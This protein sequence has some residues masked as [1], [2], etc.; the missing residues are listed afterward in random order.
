MP[1][2][3]RAA[4][5]SSQN[6]SIHQKQHIL[7]HYN[8][9]K[10]LN[11][12]Y[13][14]QD[15]ADWTRD[16]YKLSYTP[17]RSTIHRI[18]N[19]STP[20]SSSTSFK[21]KAPSNTEE[22]DRL[23]AEWVNSQPSRGVMVNGHLIKQQGQILQSRLNTSLP[24]DQQLALKFSN[25]WL[26][27]FCNRHSFKLQIAHGE[28]G[29]VQQDVIDKELPTLKLLIQQYHPADV[30]NADETGLFYNMPPNKTIGSS[31]ASGLKKNKA[32]ITIL[33]ACN[34]T[35]TEKLDP[36]FIGH[37]QQ[38]HAFKKQSPEQLG[39]Q[40][41]ANSK[42]WMTSSLFH[43]W[44]SSLDTYIGQTPGRHIL[45]LLDNFSGHG[46]LQKP[47]AKLQN[48]TIQFL[49]PNTT[50]RI[51]PLD[52]G[53]I[54]SFKKHYRAR[55]YGMALLEAELGSKDIYKLDIL[56]AIKLSQEIWQELGANI[57]KNCW[58]HTGL[59]DW[60]GEETVAEGD[61]AL[62]QQLEAS[63]RQLTEVTIQDAVQPAGEE[64]E[65]EE[66]GDAGLEEAGDFDTPT[67][68]ASP[69]KRPTATEE[70]QRSLEEQV[71]VLKLAQDIFTDQGLLTPD[72]LDAFPVCT[73][74]LIQSK[75]SN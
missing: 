43:A 54:A 37:S 9:Q 18:I 19:Q 47:L 42:A 57:I 68:P 35:G 71:R 66:E 7:T 58:R 48:I 60:G 16:T 45:L 15:L 69:G 36:F 2:S 52:A 20:D 53:I 27:K 30:F 56:T 23:L 24:V 55:Q 5:S 61:G 3:P 41:S 74:R 12:S 64:G 21:R 49:P 38:P 50:S 14:H 25:G 22:L 29:S 70:P 11:A 10:A 4:T 26:E 1:K 59:V 6:L 33:F 34:S 63:I 73:A 17:S 51:Q 72:L 13:S 62:D 39:I 65:E 28:A 67:P 8:T 31:P 44:L 32:R 75:D 46:M 40:Y